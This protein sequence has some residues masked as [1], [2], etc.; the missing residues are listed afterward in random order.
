[1]STGQIFAVSWPGGRGL[2]VK[3]Q[4]R[5]GISQIMANG[6]T[7][8]LKPEGLISQSESGAVPERNCCEYPTFLIRASSAEF[9]NKSEKFLGLD[10][11]KREPNNGKSGEYNK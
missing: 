9:I 6:L 7:W 8:P 4:S 3:P 10:Y 1:M 5:R 2:Q 11:M